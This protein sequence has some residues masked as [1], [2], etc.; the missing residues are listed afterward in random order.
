[1]KLPGRTCCSLSLTILFTALAVHAQPGQLAPVQPTITMQDSNLKPALPGALAG[2]G[3]DQKLD[4][5][6]P[7]NL[8]FI[9]ESGATVPLS[10]CHSLR[11][12]TAGSR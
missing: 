9:D 5:Q 12:S 8:N 11:S 2:V 3:I 1:M 6:T 4:Y 10:S 7:L